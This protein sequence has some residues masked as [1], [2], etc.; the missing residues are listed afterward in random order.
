[1]AS[2]I[3]LPT[4]ELFSPSTI[5]G[6]PF[7][8][9]DKKSNYLK[10]ENKDFF[11][12]EYR[13]FPI[14]FNN[15]GSQ[16]FLAN[17]YL[18]N[19]I[20]INGNEKFK[21][22]ESIASDLM[23][24]K[25]W[26]EDN[27]VDYLKADRKI[28]TPTYRY[29]HYLEGLGR[30]G[31]IARGTM[32]RRIGTACNFY[33]WLKDS[34]NYHFKFPL[35]KES[36]F[37]VSYSNSKGQ[38]VSKN[39]K[40]KDVARIKNTTNSLA[41]ED[42]IEDGGKLKPLSTDEQK[43]IFKALGQIENIE[44]SLIFLLAVT[45]GARIQTIGTLRVDDF[46]RVSSV[47][48]KEIKIRTGY[49]TLVATKYEKTGLI[50]VPRE[51]YKKIQIYLASERYEKRN[52]KA[53]PFQNMD[54]QYAF[55]TTRGNP[56]YIH[57]SDQYLDKYDNPPDGQSIRV[58]VSGK[59]KKC[60]KQNGNNIDF[61]FHDLRASYGMNLL[62]AL[63]PLVN[64]GEITLTDAL[65]HVRERLNHNNLTTTERYLNFKTKH[66]MKEKQQYQINFENY[67][68]NLLD[69]NLGSDSEF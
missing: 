25:T 27:D 24:F 58:F 38:N 42:S 62:D 17:R 15:D 48:E 66:K 40:S 33:E 57:P 30:E 49:G 22:L 44:F 67:L 31:L 20:K 41:I 29:R 2:K 19:R 23:Q 13:R 18:L 10:Q 68:I 51:V 12:E 5:G 14:I 63:M 46:K 47:N 35:W 65:S 60:L 69:N 61:R 53:L 56:F 16:W 32:K 34:E 4:I 6:E 45:T 54:H 8:I 55:L 26:C 39:V 59:L 3:I 50:Y 37:I 64:N 1:M 52:K 21:T 11:I 7:L 9:N 36:I 43:S 28:S